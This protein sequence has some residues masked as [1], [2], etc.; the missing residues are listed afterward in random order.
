MG[1]HEPQTTALSYHDIDEPARY[2]YHFHDF[3]AI[4]QSLHTFIGKR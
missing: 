4:D 1:N 3:V 2:N